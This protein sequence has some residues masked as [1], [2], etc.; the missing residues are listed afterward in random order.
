MFGFVI[1]VVFFIAMA[2]NI[3]KEDMKEQAFKKRVAY[4]L[5]EIK[6]KAKL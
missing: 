4:E 6:R 5:Y 2:R 3:W 1:G